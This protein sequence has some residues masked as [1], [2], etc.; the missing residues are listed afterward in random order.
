M[1]S[2]L[3]NFSDLVGLTR[4]FAAFVLALSPLALSASVAYAQTQPPSAAKSSVQAPVANSA[5]PQRSV[6]SL[7]QE[8]LILRERVALLEQRVQNSVRA[9]LVVDF[10]NRLP[11]SG[12]INSARGR[13]YQALDEAVARWCQ[14]LGY[15]SG[16]SLLADGIT[17]HT[18]IMCFD[19][20]P[21]EKNQ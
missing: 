7:E 2:G 4:Y 17:P 5:Q 8:V 21:E 11:K 19:P 14:T 20:P 10:Q 13:G 15:R 3:V 9:P 18:L 6:A 1:K 16:Q 12:W